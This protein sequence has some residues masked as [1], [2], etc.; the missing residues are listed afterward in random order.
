MARAHIQASETF[1]HSLILQRKSLLFLNDETLQ[2]TRHLDLCS[3]LGLEVTFFIRGSAH[4]PPSCVQ[5]RNHPPGT[6][7]SLPFY[8]HSGRQLPTPLS[9]AQR[10]GNLPERSPPPSYVQRGSHLLERLSS[11]Y[12]MHRK[13]RPMSSK[14]G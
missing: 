7:S 5:R 2:S 1:L 3:R 14:G 8:A 12:A 6:C 13:G 11:P 4:T 9:Y 10:V